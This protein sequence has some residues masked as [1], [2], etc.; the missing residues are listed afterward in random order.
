MLQEWKYLTAHRN[1]L[2]KKKGM[3]R[4]EDGFIE[5][6]CELRK[7]RKRVTLRIIWRK[8]LKIK[9]DFC[10]YGKYHERMKN[11]FYHGFKTQFVC[12]GQK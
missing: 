1:R 4:M 6:I 7:K 9:P 12:P 11:W 2:G 10:N 8:A 5:Y 3:D